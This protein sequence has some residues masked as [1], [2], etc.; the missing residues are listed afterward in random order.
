M[1]NKKIFHA[2][3]DAVQ[4][5][6]RDKDFKIAY[7]IGKYF[8]RKRKLTFE[9]LF[10]FLFHQS[11]KSLSINIEDFIENYPQLGISDISKQAVSKAR[12]GICVEAFMVLL[13]E[14]YQMFY[15]MSQ[16][17]KTWHG[18]RIF[19]IDGTTLQMP[20][21][22]ENLTEFGFTTNQT[23]SRFPMAGASALMDVLNDL[24]IDARLNTRIYPERE[25]ALEHM[26]AFSELDM[27]KISIILFDRGYPSH[28]LFH[29]LS[30]D[31]IFYLMR[32]TNDSQ[33]KRLLG[34]A[35]DKVISYGRGSYAKYRTDV[36]ALKVILDNGEAEYLLTNVFDDNLTPDMF[37]RLYNL[38]WGIETKY[39]EL[40]SRLEIESFS[41]HRPQVVRQDYYLALFFSNLVAILKKDI[42]IMIETE[43]GNS[44]ESKP[45]SYQCNRTFLINRIKKYLVKMFLEPQSLTELIDN[46]CVRASKM[47]SQIRRQRK[48]ERKVRHP[49]RK[50]DHNRKSCI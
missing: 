46:I 19:A 43:T 21:T 13:K 29:N 39:Q 18:Y 33:I 27:K 30:Q 22:E 14:T 5:L 16:D 15:K 36:R 35:D 28:K 6:L 25:F 3:I 7:R 8:T 23:G 26:E 47:R 34:D 50:Y 37:K 44:A 31:G 38:R 17:I 1:Q 45:Y 12:K 10:Y 49:R 11:K 40:K 2:I 41:G 4:T 42:D 24:I 9:K 20:Q 48:Y 32:L